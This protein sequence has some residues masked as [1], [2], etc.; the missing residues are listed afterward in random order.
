MNGKTDYFWGGRTSNTLSNQKL[1]GISPVNTNGKIIKVFRKT[2]FS[3]GTT[4]DVD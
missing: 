1:R 2:T 3:Q 4:K